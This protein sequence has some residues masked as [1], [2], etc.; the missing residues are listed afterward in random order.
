MELR[1]CDGL[2]FYFAIDILLQLQNIYQ[3]NMYIN[4]YKLIN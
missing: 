4:I 1:V 2:I 3:Y